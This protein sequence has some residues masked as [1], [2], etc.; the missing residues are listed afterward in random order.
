MVCPLPGVRTPFWCHEEINYY[1]SMRRLNTC[2]T[3]VTVSSGSTKTSG[4]GGHVR[5]TTTIA[6]CSSLTC[7]TTTPQNGQKDT[8]C[9]H[10]KCVMYEEFSVNRVYAAKKNWTLT[11]FCFTDFYKKRKNVFINIA[12]I[13]DAVLDCWKHWGKKNPQHL[14]LNLMK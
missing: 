2:Q 1:N 11:D 4:G 6:T 3:I 10:K 8:L 14:G 9:F 13:N 7:Y 12:L 5:Q